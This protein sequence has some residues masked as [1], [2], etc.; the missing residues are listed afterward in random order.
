MVSTAPERTWTAER[1]PLWDELAELVAEARRG[2]K[3]MP[4]DR[5][6]LLALRYQQ[7][8]A[9]L[10]L[11]RTRNPSSALLPRLNDLVAQAHAVVYRRPATPLRA[12]LRFVWIGYPRLVWELRRPIAAAAALGIA[13]ALAGFAWALADPLSASSF[14]PAGLRDVNHAQHDAIPTSLMAP[15]SAMIFTNNIRVDIMAFGGGLT[16]GL[17]TLYVIY[18]NSMLLGVLSG[19]TNSDGVNGEYWSLILPHGVIELSCFAI[20]AGAGLALADGIVRARPEPRSVVIRHEAGRGI[21]VVLGTM[22]LLVL[23]GL[24]EGFITPSSLPISAKLAVAAVSGVLL[25]GYLMRGRPTNRP[26]TRQD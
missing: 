24:I 1:A 12:V 4:A 8:A 13:V 15:E 9:D 20:T 10:A 22:P 7:A 14:L 23:A 25:A 26:E 18:F 2:V 19:I 5:V 6:D 21:L 11:L 16:A 17:L 3:R